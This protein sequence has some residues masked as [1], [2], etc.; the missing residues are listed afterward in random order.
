MD[1]IK[2]DIEN[3]HEQL[4]EIFYVHIIF[5]EI[6]KTTTL[7]QD[8]QN[9][10]GRCVKFVEETIFEDKENVYK[11]AINNDDGKIHITVPKYTNVNTN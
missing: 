8:L 2:N 9:L 10:V 7:R 6:A 4:L 3:K 5:G 11:V 1:D